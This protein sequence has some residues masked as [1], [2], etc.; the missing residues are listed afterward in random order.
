MNNPNQNYAVY[1]LDCIAK[2]KAQPQLPSILQSAEDERRRE[3]NAQLERER[4]EDALMEVHTD[5][6]YEREEQEAE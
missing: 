6:I 5:A 2:A 3:L 1:E 4:Y